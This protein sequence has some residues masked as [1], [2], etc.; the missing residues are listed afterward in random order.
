MTLIPEVCTA[1]T[2]ASRHC[3]RPAGRLTGDCARQRAAARYFSAMHR[4]FPHLAVWLV[5]L[6]LLAAC[7]SGGDSSLSRMADAPLPVYGLGDSYQFSD[8]STATVVS[9]EPDTVHWRDATGTFVSPRDI[10]LPALTWS[11]ATTQGD[12]RM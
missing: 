4:T 7:S 5:S 3:S 6:A 12:R 9:A 10:L 2:C 11:D 8:G 1:K